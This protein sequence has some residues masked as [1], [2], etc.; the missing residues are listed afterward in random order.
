LFSINPATGQLTLTNFFP[1]KGK[2]P[3][4]FAID[5]TGNFLLAANEKSN[6]ILVFRIDPISGNLTV[7]RQPIDVPAPVDITF[8]ALE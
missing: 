8:A 3:R 6:N 1:S 2:T 4:K 5:P 7:V